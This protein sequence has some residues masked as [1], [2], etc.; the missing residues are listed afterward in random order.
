MHLLVL[1]LLY[2]TVALN[3]QTEDLPNLFNYAWFQDN[4][5]CGYVLKPE[6]L[7][8]PSTQFDPNAIF[9]RNQGKILKLR[10]IS[11]Q[12]IPKAPGNSEV[13]DPYV[14]IKVRTRIEM[15]ITFIP[16]LLT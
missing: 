11:G 10:I 14:D 9:D 5:N 8:N 2:F 13:V 3:Y 4:G 12:H 6:F 7:R 1:F 16:N 15:P